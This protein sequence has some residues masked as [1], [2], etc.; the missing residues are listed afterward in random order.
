MLGLI[1]VENKK[2]LLMEDINLLKNQWQDI[3]SV[4]SQ[5]PPY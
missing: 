3:V 1:N 5:D 2:F 4:T